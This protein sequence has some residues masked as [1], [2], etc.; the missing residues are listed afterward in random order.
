MAYRVSIVWIIPILIIGV[1]FFF[2]FHIFRA[3]YANQNQHGIKAGFQSGQPVSDQYV[4]EQPRYVNPISQPPTNHVMEKEQEHVHVHEREQRIEHQ[5]EIQ[6][7]PVVAGQTEDDLTAPEPLQ[8]TPPTTFYEPPEATDPMNK[9]VHMNATFGS[10]LRHPE[11]MIEKRPR[12]TMQKTVQSGVANENR[13]NFGE[14]GTQYS[15]EMIQ[16]G[17]IMTDGISA[18]DK[19]NSGVGGSLAFS[20]L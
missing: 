10:N 1:F 13:F 15:E 7:V 3:A 16:N 19:T 14:Q 11:Q 8:E 6:R 5:Q 17:A 4:Q 2:S 9:T 20:M 12:R 18:H